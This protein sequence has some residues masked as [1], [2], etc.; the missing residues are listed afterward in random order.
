MNNEVFID[1]LVSKFVNSE[2]SLKDIL[3]DAINYKKDASSYK[4]VR[5]Y[6]AGVFAGYIEKKEGNE[7]TLTNARRIW[8]WE[9][10]ASLS[11]LAQSGTS[12]PNSCKFT[13]PA[14]RVTLLN[15]IE[16]LDVTAEAKNII[17]SV[18]VWK[19]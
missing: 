1:E 3:K 10:A 4:I 8:K 19:A 15:V 5:T 16:I 14:D 11:Q 13:E 2:K 12:K 7:V 17:E 18:P 6:S 9:G